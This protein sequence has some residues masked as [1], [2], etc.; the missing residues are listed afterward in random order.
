M[1]SGQVV[2]K[3]SVG[4]TGN[5]NQSFPP[6]QPASTTY[7]DKN[8]Y[9]RWVFTLNNPESGH[10]GQ[11]ID[12]FNSF[13]EYNKF[14]NK[15]REYSFQKEIGENGTPHLQGRFKLKDRMRFSTLK[16]SIG[17]PTIHLEKENNEEASKEYCIKSETST[18]E[19]YSGT[20]ASPLIKIQLM[21]N[22]AKIKL[23][24][25]E[26][27]F[28]INL[29]NYPEI[30]FKNKLNKLSKCYWNTFEELCDIDHWMAINM[31]LVMEHTVYINN[32]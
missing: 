29:L 2:K 9:N 30:I 23:E 20:G 6:K 3:G 28:E 16:K 18:G 11:L 22:D 31:A 25:F 1:K 5:T 13:C 21:I 15:I 7:I 24:H 12:Y 27:N 32:L 26:N 19:Q 4:K 10:S 17:I 8:K 14:D